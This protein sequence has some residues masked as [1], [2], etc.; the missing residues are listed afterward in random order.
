ML[1]QIGRKCS[2]TALLLIIGFA[3]SLT[4][5]LTGIGSVN[6]ILIS[7]AETRSEAPIY[8][9]MQN[10]GLSLALAIYLFSV[11]NCL[12]VTNYWMIAKQRD[13]AIRKAFGW[14]DMQLIGMIIKQ[15]ANMLAISLC[16]S[17]VLI[18]LLGRWKPSIFSVQFTPFF[19]LGTL[20]LLL[21]TLAVSTIIPAIRILKI[22]PAEVIS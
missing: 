7:L 1:Q 12:V 19:L 4:S 20:A 2:P 22:H 6:A 11:A 10:T 13:M 18:F 15:M 3:I 14:T 8:L 21:F 5:V 9:T 16:L 17:A